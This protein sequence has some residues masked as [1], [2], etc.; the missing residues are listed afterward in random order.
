MVIHPVQNNKSMTKL[1]FMYDGIS[2]PFEFST[3]NNFIKKV[4]DNV[5]STKKR[6][7][8]K[9]DRQEKNI[10]ILG[11]WIDLDLCEKNINQYVY[12]LEEWYDK[13]KSKVII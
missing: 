3:K 6:N 11:F 1:V 13:T 4:L 5:E 7:T 10:P 8:Y 9:S 12:T 2:I